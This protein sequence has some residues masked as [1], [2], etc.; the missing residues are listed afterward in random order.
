MK[1]FTGGE[2]DVQEVMG[3]A[4]LDNSELVRKLLNELI[5]EKKQK[6]EF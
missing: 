5:E 4:V 6:G 2:E 3:K 1:A